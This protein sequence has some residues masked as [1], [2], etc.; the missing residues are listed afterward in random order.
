[1]R[2]LC[3]KYLLLSVATAALLAVGVAAKAVAQDAAQVVAQDAISVDGISGPSI[4]TS[5]PRNGDPAGIRRWLA[6]RGVVYSLLYVND[7]LAN[8]RG[9]LRRGVV[10]QGKLEGALNIDLEKLAGLSGLSFYATMFQIHNTGRIR[11]DYVG[12]INTVA[13][14]EA[15]PTTRLSELWLEQKLLNGAASIRIGQLT[16]DSEFL[17]NEIAAP[18][19]QSDWPTI[20]A[21]NLPSGGAAYPLATPGVRFKLDPTP[22][23]SLLL[24]VLNGDPAGPGE[25]DEQI[26][27]RYGLN[28]RVRDPAFVIGEAQFRRNHRA[29][30]AGPATTLKLGAWHHFGAF[31]DQRFAVGGG[32]L[33]DAAASG[34]PIAHRGNS[35]V[36]YV[37]AHQLYR[38]PGGG[39][40]SGVTIF[41]RA[42]VSP[43]D[44]SLIN[45]FVD[46]GLLF[47]GLI[48]GRPDD[49][50]GVSAMRARYSNSVRGFDAD[51]IALSGVPG[52]IRDH[53][54]SLELTYMAQIIPGWT[55]QPVLQRIWHPSGDASRNATVV[56]AR[57]IW[58][59]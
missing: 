6:E 2:V 25:G 49:K 20:A 8:V 54:T 15:V 41:S 40:D 37:F 55:V 27:N 30:D 45:L 12:G 10:D 36:Y 38:P 31:D 43:S 56:G 32:L 18:F 51:T 48:P 14:I 16:A 46:G 1:M 5:L 59:Y 21:A 24:A 34:I 33:A 50:F 47:A 35:G 23:V 39:P 42:S 11:R 57:S 26:R 58:R 29:E 17:V 9:G 22:D 13:A 7:L 3:A 28:F 4:A 44:R 19:L 52:V 53:E